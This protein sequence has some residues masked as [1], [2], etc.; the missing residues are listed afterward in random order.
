MKSSLGEPLPK[1]TIFLIVVS[2][3][4]V[5]MPSTSVLASLR[6][7][8]VATAIVHVS[9]S[10]TIDG[11]KGTS[12]QTIFPGNQVVT[13]PG[14]ESIIDLGKLTRLRLLPETDLSLDFSQSRI[15]STLHKGTVRAFIPAGL[16]VNIHTAGGELVSNPAQSTEFTIQVTDRYTQIS[17]K[18]GDV[19]L[20]TESELRTIGAGEAFA[21]AGE[22]QDSQA[23][24]DEGL[25]TGQKVGI[26]AAIG[27]A[28]AILI[29]VFRGRE[30]KEEPEFGGCV[31]VPSGTTG[32]TGIC[33]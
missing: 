21:T 28:A 26:F 27:A 33:A 15:S 18:Y 17:V 25:S 32:Q 5:L 19:E 30:K 4:N 20:R 14:A 16:P 23:S 29:V 10:V 9:G 22:T 7:D 24:D 8:A 31:I 13:G 12:G 11:V 6:S 1:V 3:V 2:L